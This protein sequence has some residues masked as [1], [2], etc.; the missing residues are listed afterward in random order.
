MIK[1]ESSEPFQ[2]LIRF[3]LGAVMVLV[4]FHFASVYYTEDGFW[5]LTRLFNLNREKNVPT[6]FSSMLLFSCAVMAFQTGTLGLSNTGRRSWF[7]IAG[8]FV[9][10]SCDEV[11]A[12]H[13]R[14]FP[15]AL[16]KILYV[17][18]YT[19]NVESNLNHWAFILG[20]VVVMGAFVYFKVFIKCLDGSGEALKRVLSG[21][22]FLLMGSLILEYIGDSL[23]YG[24]R[25]DIWEVWLVWEEALEMIGSITILSGIYVHQCYLKQRIRQTA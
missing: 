11:A 21:S 10:L 9:F 12:M 23:F 25:R 22:I 6:W 20:P 19:N 24:R 17:F 1:E 4:L 5:E 8:I 13:E 14:L 18:G 2:T 16:H 7:F 3:S 15:I